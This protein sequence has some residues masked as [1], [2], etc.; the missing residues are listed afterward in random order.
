MVNIY[1]MKDWLDHP[2]HFV[3]QPILL[4]ERQINDDFPTS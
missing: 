3:D 1:P 2:L 4:D